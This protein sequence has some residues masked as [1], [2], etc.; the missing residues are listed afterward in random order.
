MVRG[1][2]VIVLDNHV[3][4]VRLVMVHHHELAPVL[5]RQAQQ[6]LNNLGNN[7]NTLAS[8]FFLRNYSIL[9]HPL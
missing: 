9:P 6:T 5:Y 7:R 2:T 8:V 1:I 3:I 4:R